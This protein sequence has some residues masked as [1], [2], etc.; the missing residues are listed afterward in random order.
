MNFKSV[1][2][3]HSSLVS[4]IMDSMHPLEV[5]EAVEDWLKP[6]RTVQIFPWDES[7]RAQ[8]IKVFLP[9]SDRLSKGKLKSGRSLFIRPL[10]KDLLSIGID[11]E[12][13]N[14]ADA[15]IEASDNGENFQRLIALWLTEHLRQ[16]GRSQEKIALKN[17]RLLDKELKVAMKM[18]AQDEGALGEF[19]EQFTR[20][21]DVQGELLARPEWELLEKD[22]ETLAKKLDKKKNWRLLKTGTVGD[23]K[24]NG[25]LYH[26][27]YLKG[28]ALFVEN[29]QREET[30]MDIVSSYL[31]LYSLRRRLKSWE[32]D[33]EATG[34]GPLVEEAFQNIPLP[35]LLIGNNDE[36]LQHNTA[37][38]KLNQTPSNVK[39]MSDYDQVTI[40]GQTWSVRKLELQGAEGRRYIF[41]FLP[42]SSSFTGQSV[43]SGQDLGIITSSIAHE[44]NNPLAGLLTALELMS[45]DE[46]WDSESRVLLNE[47]KEGAN[48]CKQLVETFL[49]FSRLRADASLGPDKG[50]VKQVTEQ[51]LNL[52]RFRMVESGLRIQLSYEQKHPY[53]YP[54]HA[55]SLTMAIYLVLGEYMTAIHHLKLLERQA[56]HGIVIEGVVIEDADS[57]RLNLKEH[58]PKPLI[59]SSKLL[60][61]LLQQERLLLENSGSEFIFTHQNVLI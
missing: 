21:L 29:L 1:L 16:L 15:V 6:L 54:I 52:Q 34:P 43:G 49:G 19:M 5:R 61:Y 46:H 58:L 12:F 53:A 9:S 30:P 57:F 20:F 45:M 59:I 28:A 60:Q 48:R 17:Q 36:V 26:L 7:E 18:I 42:V 25:V 37:F 8:G 11:Q 33:K 10:H 3:D 27:G 41:T 24:K 14:Y 31:V 38:V 22:L 50:L 39:K 40:K 44:L 47:M 51:A 35:M 2:E 13:E 55:P 23:S 4:I 56:A 32:Q